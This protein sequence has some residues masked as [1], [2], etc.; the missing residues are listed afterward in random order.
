MLLLGTG[1][2]SGPSPRSHGWQEEQ[3][4]GSL[5]LECPGRELRPALLAVGGRRLCSA[6]EGTSSVGEL[7]PQNCSPE[8]W[9]VPAL[10]PHPRR[11]VCAGQGQECPEAPS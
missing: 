4:L 1:I 11:A 10:A 5:C 7:R 3:F 9:W 8:H 6:P 2:C